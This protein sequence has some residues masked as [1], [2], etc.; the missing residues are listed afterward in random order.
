[1][2]N[3][4][5][6]NLQKPHFIGSLIVPYKKPYFAHLLH[7][8]AGKLNQGSKKARQTHQHDIYHI[9]L[10]TNGHG[11]F[12]IGNKLIRAEPGHLF[13]TSPKEPHSFLNA[14][15]ENAQYSEVTFEFRNH[16]GEPL[17]KPFHEVLSVWAGTSCRSVSHTIISGQL[18]LDLLHE[19]E[20]MI[21]QG[22]LQIPNLELSLNTSL[23]KIFLSLVHHINEL[24]DTTASNRID[25]VQEYI[26]SNVYQ[27]LTLTRLAKLASLS[28]SYLSRRFKQRFGIPPMV[29]Q[30]RLRIQSAAN[31]LRTTDYPIKHISEITGFSDIYF[32]SRIFKKNQGQPPG[33]F[34]KTARNT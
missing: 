2:K 23:N 28:P 14:I 33:R 34:R 7:A 22:S 1:M 10:V 29:F 32:F 26:R 21:R 31:L 25:E 17:T 4:Q 12:V 27:T 5:F 3:Q 6:D 18:H 16:E 8:A 19:I 30:Q 9:V 11:H 20:Q 24:P 15:G 13:L